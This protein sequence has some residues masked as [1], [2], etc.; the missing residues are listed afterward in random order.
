MVWGG[1][2]LSGPRSR[3]MDIPLNQSDD[4]CKTW[5]LPV[6][7]DGVI[8]L[9]DDLIEATGW[10]K[11]TPVYWYP[12]DDGSIIISDNHKKPVGDWIGYSELESPEESEA[13][14][15]SKTIA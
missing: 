13:E 3:S 6:S 4:K 2:F 10:K 7:E 14:N 12:Q 1:Y 5:R 9:P 15:N 8:E 11:G